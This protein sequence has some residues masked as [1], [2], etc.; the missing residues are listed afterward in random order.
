MRPTSVAARLELATLLARQ[1]RYDDAAAELAVVLE[2]DPDNLS[3]VALLGDIRLGQGRVEEAIALYRRAQTLSD[4]A[5]VMVKLHRA[6][7]RAGQADLAL[8]ELRAW[9]EAH[10][11]SPAV[12]LVLADRLQQKGDNESALALYLRLAELQPQN[13][14]VHNNLANMLMPVDAERALAAALRAQE[15]APD[16]P[17]VLDTLGWVLVQLGDLERGLTRLREAVIRNSRSPTLRYHLAVALRGV[18]QQGRGPARVAQGTDDEGAF[19]GAGAGQ[20]KAG[21]ARDSD[22]TV[23]GWAWAPCFAATL[24]SSIIARGNT[25]FV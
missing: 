18:W 21:A 8:E 11:D 15:L 23:V 3:S 24:C 22:R 17:A 12:M 19:S 1:R 2:R 14:I 7:V 4:Q 16:N 5:D 25:M 13:A 9:N 10:P 20:G 6:L